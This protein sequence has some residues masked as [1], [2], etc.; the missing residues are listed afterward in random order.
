MPELQTKVRKTVDTTTVLSPTQIARN[1]AEI[2]LAEHPMISAGGIFY[3]QY[4]F[5]VTH[6]LP[7]P[8][9]FRLIGPGIDTSKFVNIGIA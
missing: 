7:L 2:P 4:G 6:R 1:I 8:L 3:R 5:R 9:R